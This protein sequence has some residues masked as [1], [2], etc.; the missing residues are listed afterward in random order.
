MSQKKMMT[1]CQQRVLG[2]I[3]A[4]SALH[5]ECAV[6]KRDI[7]HAA[8][9]SLITVDRAV[10]QLKKLGVIEVEP[11]FNEDGGQDRNVYRLLL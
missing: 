6:R 11:R 5:G 10:K 9:C 1:S 4:E 3:A 2:V 8:D 7:A